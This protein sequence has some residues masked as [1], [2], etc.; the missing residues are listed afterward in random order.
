MFLRINMGRLGIAMDRRYFS[1][2][3]LA[4]LVGVWRRKICW[5]GRER[6]A[7]RLRSPLSGK[8]ESMPPS[9][10]LGR[11]AAA[12]VVPFLPCGVGNLGGVSVGQLRRR[13][14]RFTAA[15]FLR[16][17]ICYGERLYNLHFVVDFCSLVAYSVYRRQ[18]H[19]KSHGGE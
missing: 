1:C 13:L 4:D 5:L 7:A 15:A 17:L 14:L 6:T 8:V 18:R 10:I 19:N 16:R 3:I 11:W 12:F 2:G 9:V